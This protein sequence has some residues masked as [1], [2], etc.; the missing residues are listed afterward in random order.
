MPSSARRAVPEL[1]FET[2]ILLI[3]KL[4]ILT[5]NFRGKI[6]ANSDF[7]IVHYLLLLIHIIT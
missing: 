4:F 3:D 6:S 2:Y 1:N 5:G 7:E